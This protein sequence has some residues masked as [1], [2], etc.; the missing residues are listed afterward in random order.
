MDGM[1]S[2]SP[3]QNHYSL[4]SIYVQI[5]TFFPGNTWNSQ[6][7]QLF[8]RH[9]ISER[10]G[11]GETKPPSRVGFPMQAGSPALEPV[12]RNWVDRPA[13]LVT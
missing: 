9:R 1:G 13:T 3:S 6:N 10:R 2:L 8:L 12:G 5:E 7:T 4:Y 11:T